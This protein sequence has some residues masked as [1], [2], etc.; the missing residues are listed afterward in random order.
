M[1][2]VAVEDAGAVV[3]LRPPAAV[4]VIARAATD[5]VVSAAKVTA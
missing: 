1:A 2:G 4:T 3:A 5:P